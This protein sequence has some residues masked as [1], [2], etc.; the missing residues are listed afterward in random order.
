M[1]T[2]PTTMIRL[3]TPFAPLF[4]ERVWQHVQL[5][6]VGTILAPGKRT[7]ASAL[8]AVG[9][10]EERQFCRYHRVLN[11]AVWSGNRVVR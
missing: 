3:L 10:E 8:R 2:L 9:L 5:L 4:S 6:L 11:R 1:R 7:V